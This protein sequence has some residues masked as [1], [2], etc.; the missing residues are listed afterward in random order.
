MGWALLLEA[1]R[2]ERVCIGS[3]FADTRAGGISPD[4]QNEL[5]KAC[6]ARQLAAE[7]LAG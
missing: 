1:L 5:K 2:A 3:M 4:Q 7:K 6:R